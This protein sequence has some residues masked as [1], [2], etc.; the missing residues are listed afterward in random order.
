MSARIGKLAVIGTGLIGGS[1]ALALKKQQAV[2]FVVGCG[3]SLDNLREAL[4]MGIIDDATTDPAEAVTGADLV[5]LAVPVGE[6]SKLCLKIAHKLNPGA[7]VT[8]A[9]STK[10]IVLGELFAHLPPYVNIVGGHP[11]AGREKTGAAAA[12]EDLFKDRITILTPDKTTDPD[13]LAVVKKLWE[14]AGSRVEIM[15]PAEHD[16][17]LGAVS[18]LPHMVAYALVET[19]MEWDKEE[20]LLRFSAGG[21]RDFTRIAASSPEMWRDICQDNTEA[22]IESIDRF[23]HVLQ[24]LRKDI[25]KKDGQALTERFERARDVRKK[26]RGNS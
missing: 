22:I 4:A 16:I 5:F 12:E 25:K 10:Q 11:I 17:A 21:L 2:D 15:E 7:I 24:E 23:A 8:D 26:M 1:F 13:A 3:R 14:A 9:G 6:I 19:L 20:S 18:H